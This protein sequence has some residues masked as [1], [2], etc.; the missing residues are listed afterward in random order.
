MGD[1][2]LTPL[3][4]ALLKAW[5]RT[6]AHTRQV[7]TAIDLESLLLPTREEA[8]TIGETFAHLIEVRVRRVEIIGGKNALEEW[9]PLGDG[10]EESR[11]TLAAALSSSAERVAAV[12]TDLLLNDSAVRGFTDGVPGWIGYQI[13]HE[14]H[15]RGQI[16]ATLAAKGTPLPSKVA[17]GV[18]DWT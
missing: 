18:W 15:H 7:L 2:T 13:A 5:F 6:D 1:P 14:A 3:A 11:E 12:A 16:L 8:R 17:Y 10:D 4:E 9:E